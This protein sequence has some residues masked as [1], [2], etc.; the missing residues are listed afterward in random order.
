MTAEEIR[1][2]L[3]AALHDALGRAWRMASAWPM[4][5]EGQRGIP[6]G[7]PDGPAEAERLMGLA[8]AYGL[9]LASPKPPAPPASP[10]V[11]W[12]LPGAQGRTACRRGDPTSRFWPAADDPHAVTCQNCKSR[13]EWQQAA[14]AVPLQAVAEGGEDP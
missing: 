10:A 8:D 12:T 13:P 11:H 9:A 7:Y 2:A 6:P 1:E 3:E 4:S 5:A 14:S